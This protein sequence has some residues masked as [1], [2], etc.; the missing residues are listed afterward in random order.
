[1]NE[2][3]NDVLAQKL[4]RL[5]PRVDATTAAR[6]ALTAAQR[7][8]RAPRMRGA[9]A[10]AVAAVALVALSSTAVAQNWFTEVWK[11]GNV[12]AAASRPVSLSEART[13]GLPV[14]ESPDLPG[15]WKL[16]ESGAVQLTRTPDW[17]SVNLQYDREGR[18]GMNITMFRGASLFDPATIEHD[19]TL[20]VSGRTVYVKRGAGEVQ[21]FFNADDVDIEIHAFGPALAGRPLTADAIADLVRTMI[22]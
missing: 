8:E 12:F 16:R 13:T 19:E 7:K 22:G 20:S 4:S 5:E 11:I 17:T 14:P 15:G 21:A 10:I 9:W 6:D 3:E 2:F 18:R 1:M